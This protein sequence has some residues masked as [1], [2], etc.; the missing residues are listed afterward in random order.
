[1]SR[2]AWARFFDELA[3]REAESYTVTALLGGYRSLFDASGDH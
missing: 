3:R 2:L 1:M